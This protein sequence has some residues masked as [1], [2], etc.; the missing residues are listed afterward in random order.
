MYPTMLSM[1]SF[2]FSWLLHMQVALFFA[3]DVARA[4]FGR[5]MTCHGWW[6]ATAAPSYPACDQQQQHGRS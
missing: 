5:V 1:M 2:S 6:A 3:H 4:M